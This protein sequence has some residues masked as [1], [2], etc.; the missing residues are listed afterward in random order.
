[1]KQFSVLLALIPCQFC[2]L[3]TGSM[4]ALTFHGVEH[5]KG[6]N[7]FDEEREILLSLF[8]EE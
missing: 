6:T 2:E 8:S 1:M 4:E 5:K 3:L 7:V